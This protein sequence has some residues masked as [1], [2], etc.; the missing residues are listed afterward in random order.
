MKKALTMT[1]PTDC[2]SNHRSVLLI[3]D[4][5]HRRNALGRLLGMANFDVYSAASGSEAL[6]LARQAKFDLILIGSHFIGHSGAELCRHIRDFDKR[7][8]NLFYS[9][10]AQDN[11]TKAEWPLTFEQGRGLRPAYV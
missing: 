10:E 1:T 6:A 4:Q 9:G 3:D 5:P 2:V 7:T 8:P 11:E